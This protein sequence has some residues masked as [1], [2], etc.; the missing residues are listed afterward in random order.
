MELNKVLESKFLKIIQNTKEIGIKISR[1]DKVFYTIRM[2]IFIK[3]I[4]ICLKLK[5][6]EFISTQMEWNI[7]ECG[8]MIC[9][10]DKENK[11]GRMVLIIEDFLKMG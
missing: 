5:D 1:M 4:F 11:F 6:L 9:S 10:K 8:K 3:V 7:K 2:V